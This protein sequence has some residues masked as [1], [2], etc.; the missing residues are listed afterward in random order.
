MATERT[1]DSPP[2]RRAPAAEAAATHPSPLIRRLSG[3]RDPGIRTAAVARVLGELAPARAVALLRDLVAGWRLESDPTC[4]A[5]LDAVTAALVG[6]G[7]ISY[8]ARRGLYAAAVAA[9]RPVIARLFFDAWQPTGAGE[10][11]A[12]E[13]AAERPIAPRGRPLTLGERKAAARGTRRDVLLHLLRDPHPQVVGVLLAN[14]RITE[15]DVL[16]VASRRPTFPECQ[17]QVFASH[18]WRSRYP[19]KRA[20]VMNPHTPAP[21]SLGIAA[22]LRHSDLRAVARAPDLAAAVRAQARDL[23]AQYRP[24]PQ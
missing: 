2:A 6:P 13:L 14:P 8:E 23:V 18:R 11:L 7:A 5:L 3:V 17:M 21:L 9:E 16:A 19:V 15:R 4:A 10:E 20:L 12:E 22:T 24:A 1:G